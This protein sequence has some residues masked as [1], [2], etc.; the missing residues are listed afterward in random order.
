[1]PGSAVSVAELS[2]AGPSRAAVP[3]MYAGGLQEGSASGAPCAPLSRPVAEHWES[4]IVCRNAGTSDTDSGVA[5][6]GTSS[7]ERR[8]ADRSTK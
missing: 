3:G 6:A 1:M 5:A 7:G 8:P 2:E 4:L